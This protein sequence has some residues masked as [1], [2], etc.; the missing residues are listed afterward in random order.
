MR[1]ERPALDFLTDR[2]F[3]H[4]G[5]HGSGVP[6]N[7]LAAARA[8]IATGFGIE[9]DVRLNADGI[10]HVFHD[11]RLARLT[12]A[13]GMFGALTAGK[14][15]ALRLQG[16]SEAIPR[17]SALLALTADTPLLIEL[18]SD[19]GAQA[20][21]RLC[22]A[23][24]AELESY[25]GSTAVMSFDPLVCHWFARHRPAIVRGLVVSRRHRTGIVARHGTALAI[26]RAMPHFIA[27]DVRDLPQAAALA[28]RPR[29]PLLCWTVRTARDRSRAGTHVDQIICEHVA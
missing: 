7:S 12:G 10:V 26:A 23:V 4:R 20:C 1:I 29:R 19:G 24:A 22:A 28:H 3:A 5:L 25:A 2:P 17:L 8:A 18:K 16:S 13:R 14:V 15:A 27:C 9:C 21:A 11:R 6:E